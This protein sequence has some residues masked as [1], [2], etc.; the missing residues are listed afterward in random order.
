MWCIGQKSGLMKMAELLLFLVKWAK[1]NQRNGHLQGLVPELL[2]MNTE[3]YITYI[4]M[5]IIM[6][7]CAFSLMPTLLCTFLSKK[8]IT[9]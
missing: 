4:I 9:L 6:Y 3:V 5:K 7:N 8:M 2:Y 1:Q